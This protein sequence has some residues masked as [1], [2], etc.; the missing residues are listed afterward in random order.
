LIGKGI[1][2]FWDTFLLILVVLLFKVLILLALENR[3]AALKIAEK[4][5]KLSKEEGHY[6]RETEALIARIKGA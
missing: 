1:G 5:L 3:E 2:F 6:V 4:Q